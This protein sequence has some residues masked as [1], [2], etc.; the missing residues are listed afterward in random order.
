MPEQRIG[1]QAV[2]GTAGLNRGVNA[3]LSA[4]AKMVTATNAASGRL[5]IS[6]SIAGVANVNNQLA[7]L[8]AQVGAARGAFS[9]LSRQRGPFTSISNSIAK[10]SQQLQN[11]NG[12]T[13]RVNTS[14]RQMEGSFRSA[15]TALQA[16]FGAAIGTALINS[17]RDISQGLGRIVAGIAQN[18]SFWERLGVAIGFFETRT[19]GAAEAALTFAE[20]MALVGESARATTLWV[21]KLAVISPYTSQDV[22]NIFRVAQAYGLSAQAAKDLLPPLL[23]LGSAAG[24]DAD[25]LE[26]VALAMGQVQARGKLTGEEIRQLGNAG[27]PIREIL[28]KNLGIANSEFEHFVEE[29]MFTAD[30]VIPLITKALQDFDG[31]AEEISKN[32]LT[33][34]AQA[35]KETLQIG[36]TDFFGGIGEAVKEQLQD[37]VALVTNP[38]FRPMLVV[39]G[40]E[41]GKAFSEMLNAVRNGVMG[42]IKVVTSI[43]PETMKFIAVFAVGVTAAI[44]FSVALALLSSA[45]AFLINPV[46]LLS[47]AFGTL[48]GALATKN[49]LETLR[50]LL[51]TIGKG[52]SDAVGGLGSFVSR[53]SSGLRQV[54]DAFGRTSADV[55]QYSSDMFSYFVEGV[56]GIVGVIGSMISSIG[57]IFSYWM[58]PHSPP[59]FLPHIDKWGRETANIWLEGW[60]EADFDILKDVGSTM[61]NLLSSLVK[62]G[63]LGGKLNVIETMIGSRAFIKEAINQITNFG[64]VTQDV[65]DNIRNSAGAAAGAVIGYLERY[66]V[67]SLAS[68]EVAAAQERLNAITKRYSDLLRP[69]TQRLQEMNDAQTQ[70]GE[71]KEIARLQRVMASKF[72]SDARKREAALELEALLIAQQIRVTERRRDAEEGAA[73]SALDSAEEAEKRAQTE[74]DLFEERIRLQID[75]NELIQDRQQA[76]DAIA[77]ANQKATKEAEK[78]LTPLERQLKI[79][80]LQQEELRGMIDVY[81]ARRV[82]EDESATA[83]EKAAAAL[84]I[85]REGTQSMLRDI[86]IAELGGSLDDIRAIQIVLADIEKPKKG[87]AADPFSAIK[88]GLKDANESADEFAASL[89]EWDTNLSAFRDKFRETKTSIK[90]WLKE[91][92]D[93]LPDFLKLFSTRPEDDSEGPRRDPGDTDDFQ[94]DFGAGSPLLKVLGTV[95]ALNIGWKAMAGLLNG[96]VRLGFTVIRGLVSGLTWLIGGAAVGVLGWVSAAGSMIFALVALETNI[97]GARDKLEEFGKWMNKVLKENFPSL[98]PFG[99]FFDGLLKTAT[100]TYNGMIDAYNNWIETQAAPWLEMKVDDVAIWISKFVVELRRGIVRL[101]EVGR[102]LLEGLLESFGYA[103]LKKEVGTIVDNW[104]D[105][106]KT[107]FG[108]QSH[109]AKMRDEVGKPMLRGIVQ[110]FIDFMGEAWDDVKESVLTLVTTLTNPDTLSRFRDS[111]TTL[112]RNVINGIRN[113]ISGSTAIQFVKDALTTLRNNVFSED[114]LSEFFE[115]AKEAG[116]MIV[117]G[118]SDGISGAISTVQDAIQSILDLIPEWLI[119]FLTT[120]S[121]PSLPPI[122]G[123]GGPEASSDTGGARASGYSTQIANRVASEVAGVFGDTLI[124]SMQ[125][126]MPTQIATTPSGVT[127]A[128]I[129]YNYNLNTSTASPSAGVIRDFSIMRALSGA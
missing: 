31:A 66:Q 56:S 123:G 27:I 40:E 118:I 1:V 75:E 85:Q 91:I 129:N 37:I 29:G 30:V 92:N 106:F 72:V 13:I 103:K 101:K 74:L 97:G 114:F 28:V 21:Q 34:L 25:V 117:K 96:P 111:A 15:G 6:P 98:A 22:G 125:S 70:S 19:L 39:L 43:S 2:V 105:S 95:L 64:S 122:F 128:P 120:G 49:P 11:L 79:I 24:L 8:V 124:A 3:Y 44:G 50:K 100:D 108:I 62:P 94:I 113:Y 7:T 54:G 61:E 115:K 53:V 32:T 46:T 55:A 77:S 14:A 80:Q 67:L 33:G 45:V 119:T 17:F 58:E 63:D 9:A 26:R 18:V 110:A 57:S 20:R 84:L 48:L 35:F 60:R 4:L 126:F 116:A 65:F 89:L 102:L 90:V 42:L 99:D 127:A 88:D 78:G 10:M 47:V 71:A 59:R 12:Q 41:I 81:R 83:A 109:S 51:T 5:V 121:L 36:Q 23:D 104:L 93:A 52:L 68:Q 112:A 38:Q 82:L 87:A 107:F 69:L 73:E 86:E 76:I 16:G